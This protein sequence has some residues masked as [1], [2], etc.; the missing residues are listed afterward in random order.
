LLTLNQTIHTLV[1]QDEYLLLQWGK[2]ICLFVSSGRLL[3][4][5]HPDPRHGGLLGAAARRREVT[6]KI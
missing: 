4:R 6:P 3:R 2:G 1:A 5:F